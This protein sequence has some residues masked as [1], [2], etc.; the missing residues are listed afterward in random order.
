MA[1]TFNI[2]V[3]EARGAIAVP[4]DL[5]ATAIVMG[6][7]SAGSGLSPFFLS[8]TSAQA[9]VGYGDASDCL[10]QVIEQPNAGKKYPCALYTVPG[11]TPGSYGTIDIAEVDGT[12]R[13][14]NSITLAPFGTYEAAIRM[15]AGCTVGVTGGTYQWSL[16]GGRHWSNT[17]ALGTATSIS[18]PNAGTGYDLTPPA[19]QVTAF[20]AAVLEARAD[21]LAHF[22]DV[23]AHDASD[24]AAIAVITLGAPTTGA[25]AW[26]VLNQIDAAYLIHRTNITVHNG[27]DGVNVI[28][29]SAAASVPGGVANFPE[30]KLD[31]NA[32]L[33]IAL[34]ADADGLLLA[35]ASVAAPV[36]VLASGMIAGGITLLNTYPRR[37][38]ITTAGV[39][40]SDAPATALVSG[41]LF[42]VAQSETV[43]VPQTADIVSTVGAYDGTGLS[44]VYPAAQG[45]AATMAIG[46]GQAVHNSADVTNTI[47]ATSATQGTLL[48]GD[49]WTSRTLAPQPSTS[50]V[51]AAFAALKV[52]AADFSLLF[53]EFPVN[54]AMAAI[55]SAGQLEL[56]E[57]GKLVTC[58]F[59]TRIP[60]WETSE[61]DAAWNT[62]ISANF[63]DYTDSTTQKRAAYG[64]ITDAMTSNQYLRSDFAQWC[65][66]IV[67]TP[68][69]A[70]PDCPNNRIGGMPNVTLIDANGVL[71][72][73]DEG[74]AGESTGLSNPTLGNTFSCVERLPVPAVRQAVYAVAPWVS[75]D[76]GE[77]IQTLM[78]RRLADACKRVAVLAAVPQ[79]GS[80]LFYTST[81]PTSGTLTPQSLKL[82][83]SSIFAAVSGEFSTEFS[84]AS[85]ADLNTGLVQV[86]PAVTVG[87]GKLLGIEVTI[88]PNIGGYVL[89][90]TITLAVQ[91]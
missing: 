46:F 91:Q 7:S 12:C 87:A 31:Y 53:C 60:D 20:I 16:D 76:V 80:R 3:E 10:C 21:A 9:S 41:T 90:F 84:N 69:A 77:T 25:E 62:S 79:F 37:V 15:V 59:R 55:I 51:A 63:I 18:I 65:A 43:N 44:V 49:E 52:A 39:T 68:R 6:C 5:D 57:V 74:P 45:T 14:T 83:Q 28:S 82:V 13:P 67:A 19:A 24:A 1:G 23:V 54:A 86:N 38:T 11:S 61:T 33:G 85:D 64:F 8:G 26:A 88:A 36:T 89:E 30:T 72:G 22:A 70:W 47:G 78:A 29:H 71:I 32:H 50:D 48:A 40:P 2:T 58:V 81:G 75:Y 73:H 17:T 35:T 27:P 66:D 42:G 56:R 34:A 4:A